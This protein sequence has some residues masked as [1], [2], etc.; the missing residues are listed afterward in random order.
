MNFFIKTEYNIIFF[1]VI[2]IVSVLIA[3]YYYRKSNLNRNQRILFTA[4]RSLTLFFL[5]MLLSAPVISFISVIQIE[6]VNIFLIDN[7]KSLELENR[8]ITTDSVSNEVLQK[9][10]GSGA[11]NKYFSFSGSLGEEVTDSIRF[12]EIDNNETNLT[13][14][15]ISLEELYSSGNIST[16][17]IISDGILNEGGNPLFTARTLN[18]PI[19]YILIGDTA[20]KNDAVIKDVFYNKSA[21]IES[22]VP[23]KI[24]INSFKYSQNLTLN[25]YE[26]DKLLTSQNIAVSPDNILYNADFNVTSLTPG[27]KKYKVEI[28]PLDGEITDKNN[29][30]EFFIKFIDNK[31]KALVLSGGPSYDNAFIKEEIKK[32]QNF[33]TTFLTQKSAGAY[34]EGAV[35]NLSQFRVFILVGYP[36]SISN[37][38]ILS[39]IESADNNNAS[40]FFFASKNTDYSKLSALQDKLPFRAFDFSQTESETGIKTVSIIDNEAFG[41]NEILSSVNNLPAVF[42]GGTNFTANPSSETILLTASS[43]PAFVIQST[44]D[45]HSAAFLVHGLYKWRLSPRKTNGAEVLSY[46]MSTTIAY[47]A[48]KD[49]QKKFFIETTRPVYSKYEEVKFTATLNNPEIIGGEVIR[50]KVSGNGINNELELNKT[51]NTT[52]EGKMSI[53]TDGDYAY[54]AGLYIRDEFTESDEGRFIISENNYEFINTRADNSILSNLA[55]ETGGKNFSGLSPDEISSFLSERNES[56]SDEIESLKNFSLNINPY[57]LSLLILM[58]CMEWFFRKR[59]NLP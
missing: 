47:I 54:T 20:Q 53:P 21:F 36:T 37:D 40:I 9:T 46:L 32:I 29:Y 15:L 39:Q 17:N 13:S 33:E 25:L 59:N 24:E 44:E 49:K 18:A 2:M 43:E 27:I 48:D 31:F 45:N 38:E 19:S 30:R 42:K 10:G 14:S 26:E 8:N 55:N 6:P 22:T 34:Y 1:I 12:Y 51:G 3:F 23:V 7:S 57:F 52:F 41:K 11:E 56:S 35:P 4:L 28:V 58:L 50:V 5:L 16:I